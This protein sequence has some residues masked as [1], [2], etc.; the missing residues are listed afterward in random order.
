MFRTVGSLLGFKTEPCKNY[1][2]TPII[3]HSHQIR[4]LRIRIGLL[5]KSPAPYI[6]I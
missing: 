1:L 2:V 5:D 3:V 4:H 6:S